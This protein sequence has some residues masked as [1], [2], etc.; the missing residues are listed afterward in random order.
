V[1]QQLIAQQNGGDDDEDEEEDHADPTLPA[2][3]SQ[4][5]LYG[6]HDGECGYCSSKTAR[7]IR[8]WETCFALAHALMLVMKNDRGHLVW[9]VQC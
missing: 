1:L 9:H 7:V 8:I 4:A 3:A 2:N 6:S 5:K